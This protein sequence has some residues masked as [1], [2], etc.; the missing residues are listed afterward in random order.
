MSPGNQTEIGLSLGR[1]WTDGVPAPILRLEADAARR[2]GSSWGLDLRFIYEA[3][4][5]NWDEGALGVTRYFHC[6]Y[7]RLGYDWTESTIGLS[8]GIL[9]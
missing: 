1:A 9:F 4:A 3:T 5:R 2:T 8:G 6:Y 7:L